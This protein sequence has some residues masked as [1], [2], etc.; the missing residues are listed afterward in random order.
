MGPFRA[1]WGFAKC[2]WSDPTKTRLQFLYLLCF[3]ALFFVSSLCL[4][5]TV[6]HIY[7]HKLAYRKALTV[8]K[9]KY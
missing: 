8:F 4:S 2:A 1:R 6:N 7:P 5:L 3:F 9:T